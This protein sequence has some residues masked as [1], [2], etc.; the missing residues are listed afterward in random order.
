MAPSRLVIAAAVCS[1]HVLLSRL[2]TGSRCP[3]NSSRCSDVSSESS[4]VVRSR[5]GRSPLNLPISM[6]SP[7]VEPVGEDV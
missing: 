4:V 2:T 3:S 6:G 5:K 1:L 7:P